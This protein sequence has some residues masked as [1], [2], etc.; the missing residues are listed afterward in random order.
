MVD[1]VL[2]DCQ[3]GQI[4]GPMNAQEFEVLAAVRHSGVGQPDVDLWARGICL[5]IC[6]PTS[7][8]LNED[9]SDQRHRLVYG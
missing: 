8:H 1:A 3:E 2:T 7:L 9:I 4:H 5:Q 6:S